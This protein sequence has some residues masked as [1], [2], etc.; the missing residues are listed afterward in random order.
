MFQIEMLD[1]ISN[2]EWVMSKTNKTKMLLLNLNSDFTFELSSG[3]Q[4]VHN[5]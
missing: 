1:F 5:H 3:E 2:I 4:I